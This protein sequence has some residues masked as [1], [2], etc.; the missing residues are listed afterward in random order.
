M[1]IPVAQH[2]VGKRADDICLCRL[3]TAC[4]NHPRLIP[5][6]RCLSFGSI[7]VGFRVTQG[8]PHQPSPSEDKGIIES[9]FTFTFNS[10][11]CHNLRT[12]LSSTSRRFCIFFS[13]L[14]LETYGRAQLVGEWLGR[15]G[16]IAFVFTS[17]GR[18]ITPSRMKD[19]ILHLQPGLTPSILCSY[20][21]AL[22][23]STASI[24]AHVQ[25]INWDTVCLCLMRNLQVV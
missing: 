2:G 1:G 24:K 17:H 5:S 23:T 22:M 9:T 25:I 21:I 13:L 20:S 12:G 4:V 16:C 14:L 11:P 15:H 3:F 6:I 8:L 19:D 7:V 10:R 18:T